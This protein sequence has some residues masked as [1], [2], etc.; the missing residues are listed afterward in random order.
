MIHM[1]CTYSRAATIR[2]I[3]KEQRNSVPAAKYESIFI[4]IR[5]TWANEKICLAPSLQTTSIAK[6][7]LLATGRIAGM[8][9]YVSSMN[10]EKIAMTT[11]ASKMS[12]EFL[13]SL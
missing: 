3:T 9:T 10:K 11:R 4:S 12:V 13:P 5:P 2:Y 1:I 7:K 8:R 6:A